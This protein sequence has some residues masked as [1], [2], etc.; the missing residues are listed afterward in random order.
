ML[1]T[2]FLKATVYLVLGTAAA[3]I[4]VAVIGARR[5]DDN[6]TL[7]VGGSWCI[8]AAAIGLWIGRATEPSARLERLLASA[9]TTS[10]LPEV[11]PRRLIWNR[12]WPLAALVVLCGAL[13]WLYPQVAAVG[14]GY[15]VLWA[16][17][18]RRQAAAVTAIEDRDG[19]R[20]YVE[21]TSPIKPMRVV[22]TP[23]WRR[24]VDAERPA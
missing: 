21:H 16:L 7:I 10:T 12:L 18:W 13:A 22:R 4:A 6:L 15:A 14:A 19:V 8:I 9:P 3:L 24:I 20:F 5:M 1:F 23:G 17:A 2:D 11:R